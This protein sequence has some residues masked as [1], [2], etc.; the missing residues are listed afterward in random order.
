MNL[1]YSYF[2]QR[3]AQPHASFFINTWTI[4]SRWYRYVKASFSMPYSH[5][6]IVLQHVCLLGTVDNHRNTEITETVIFVKCR[7]C[8]DLAE[9]PCF[10]RVFL[11][12]CRTFMFS[13]E[14]FVSISITWSLLCKFNTK[15]FTFSLPLL[16]KS[17]CFVTYWLNMWPWRHRCMYFGSW[18]PRVLA[19]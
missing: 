2:F 1:Q 14:C 7:E 8:R 6:T 13:Q 4:C 17:V 15:I 10:C 9:V 3:A 16:P 12:K 19:N 18:K 5:V 11:P